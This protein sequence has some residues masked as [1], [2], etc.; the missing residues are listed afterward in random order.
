M[1]S[2][3]TSYIEALI[4]G[5]DWKSLAVAIVVVPILSI[6]AWW[7]VSYFTSPLRKYPGPTLAGKSMESID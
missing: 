3:D 7:I 6:T 2:I 5:L 4:Q 1:S